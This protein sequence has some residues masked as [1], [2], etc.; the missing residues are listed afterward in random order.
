[1]TETFYKELSSMCGRSNAVSELP[2]LLCMLLQHAQSQGLLLQVADFLQDHETL[3]SATE[4]ANSI[5]VNNG[6][7]R[8]ADCMEVVSA[9][10]MVELSTQHVEELLSLFALQ[11]QLVIDMLRHD[12]SQLQKRERLTF[13]LQRLPSRC[14]PLVLSAVVEDSCLEVRE[15]LLI[16]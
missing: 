14:R 15:H 4:Q 5:L 2:G 16:R 11:P 13:W 10:S 12:V 1:M 6:R 3:N 7:K 8:S 9:R